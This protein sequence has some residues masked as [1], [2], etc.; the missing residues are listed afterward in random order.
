M[1]PFEQHRTFL[2]NEHDPAVESLR[3]LTLALYNSHAYQWRARDLSDYDAHYLDIAWQL[4]ASFHRH[5]DEDPVFRE[6]ASEIVIQRRQALEQAIATV[7]RDAMR[8]RSE[9]SELAGQDDT[10]EHSDLLAER[11]R[12]LLELETEI[13]IMNE[14]LEKLV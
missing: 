13:S 9:I 6:I 5:G 1:N 8:I 4:M 14:R 7:N 2:L 3:D 10:R 11:N 12:E